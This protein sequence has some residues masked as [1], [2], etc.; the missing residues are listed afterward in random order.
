MT[1]PINPVMPHLIG[2]VHVRSSGKVRQ[3][4]Q[5]DGEEALCGVGVQEPEAHV[6][7]PARQLAVVVHVA[8]DGDEFHLDVD[9]RGQA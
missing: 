6:T 5:C 8:E 1:F 9:G 7:H 3:G 4:V 2:D